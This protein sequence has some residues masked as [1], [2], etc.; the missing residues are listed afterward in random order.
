MMLA[1]FTFTRRSPEGC[2]IKKRWN[3]LLLSS[4]PNQDHLIDTR[5]IFMLFYW[6][7]YYLCKDRLHEPDHHPSLASRRW[8]PLV[9]AYSAV[10]LNY[11]GRSVNT[12]GQQSHQVISNGKN[13]FDKVYQEMLIIVFFLGEKEIKKGE[14]W[15]VCP[16]YISF[17]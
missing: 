16:H 8:C 17:K 9:L 2:L 3:S 6:K 11:R 12:T 10:S 15:T 14:D 5:F 13:R 4:F 1:P 7:I